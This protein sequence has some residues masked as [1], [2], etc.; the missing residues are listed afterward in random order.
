MSSFLP[1]RKKR[2]LRAHASQRSFALVITLAMVAIATILLILFVTAMSLDRSASSSYSQSVKAQEIGLGGLHLVVGQLQAEMYK[3]ASPDTNNSSTA[4]AIFTN[5]SPYNIAPQANVTNSA[6]PIMVKMSTN[7]AFYS[8]T[9]STSTLLATTNSTTTSSYNGRSVSTTRWNQAYFGSFP[10][11]GAAPYW[12]LMTR[13]GPT[14]ATGISPL[15][16][17]TGTSTLNN[18]STANTNYVIGRIAYAVYDESGLL[19]INAA[20]YNT[21]ALTASQILPIKGTLA[22]ADLNA[23]GITNT[24]AFIN[25]RN[26]AS[27]ANYVSI[28]T[29]FAATNGFQS[30]YPGDTTFLSR[31]DLI[32][33]AQSANTNYTGLTLSALTNLTTFT[34]EL[35]APSWAPSLN[36][37]I[38][39]T[40]AGQASAGGYAYANNA[41]TKITSTP[42]G[43]TQGVNKSG[44]ENPNP[45]IP[46]VR[47]STGGTITGY[48]T[49]GGTFTYTVNAGDPVVQHR[50]PLDRLNWVTP[51]GPSATLS[52][53]DA[54]Y[55]AGGTAAAVQACFGLIWG[56]AENKTNG[57]DTNWS[58]INVWKYVGPTLTTET[59]ISSA[60]ISPIET[61]S[62]VA[63]ESPPR[64]P[65]FFEL[66]Q[67][68]VLPGSLGNNL[69][70]TGNFQFMTNILQTYPYYQLMRIGAN[71]ITQAQ[72]SASSTQSS[73][74][75]INIEYNQQGYSFVASGVANLPYINALKFTE[76]TSATTTGTST[77]SVTPMATYGLVSLWNPHQQSSTTLKRPNVR[78]YVQ[79]DV[80]LASGWCTSY[81][82]IATAANTYGV[83]YA[84]APST[85][86]VQL[87]NTSGT[88]TGVNGFLNPFAITA[89]D[90]DP[91]NFSPTYATGTLGW[92]SST[93][94]ITYQSTSATYADSSVTYEALRF[95]DVNLTLQQTGAGI[96][97]ES[98][99]QTEST[100]YGPVHFSTIL[101]SPTT[102]GTPTTAAPIFQMIMK[103]QD[104]NDSSGN[105]WVP[106]DYW[107]GNN[108]WATWW[109]QFTMAGPTIAPAYTGSGGSATTTSPYTPLPTVDQTMHS[110]LV[111]GN[112]RYHS[113]TMMNPDPR[114]TRF[115]IF[116]L[117]GDDPTAATGINGTIVNPMIDSIWSGSGNTTAPFNIC[118]YGGGG[119]GSPGTAGN[120]VPNELNTVPT[121]F[122]NWFLPAYLTRNNTPYPNVAGSSTGTYFTAYQD[123]DGI[124][125]IADSGLFPTTS[126]I[127]APATSGNPYY[128]PNDTATIASGQRTG[129]RPLVLNRPYASVGELGYV[130]RDD[131]WRSL[132]FFSVFNNGSTT[133]S[134]SADSGLLDLFTVVD[135][136]NTVVAG[137]VNLNTQNTAVLA[138][139]L[140]STVANTGDTTHNTAVSNLSSPAAMASALATYTLA[141]PL[142]NK[143][144]LVT[145]FNP[146][147]LPYGSTAT[148]PFG[149]TDEQNVKAYRE[150]FIRSLADVGQTRTWNLMIDLVAQAG[151]Y[152]ATA[153]NADQFVV[154]GERR[155]WLHV[156][157]DRFTGKIIDQRLEVVAP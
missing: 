57:G 65:N 30:V 148:T 64:E 141:N 83:T 131:P 136:P 18:P 29:N 34:R 68:G 45:F 3:D 95:P 28:I 123:P 54:F 133:A 134:T 76:G 41:I 39:I 98:S 25:W 53:T 23:V 43:T 107:V 144:Q 152:P 124:Q 32:A 137:R 60:N 17:A 36:G 143:D 24:A 126:P 7:I 85:Y 106:Y 50:F 109:N 58:G 52:G 127:T 112:V 42:F 92:T 86:Y 142:V 102:T 61:L 11:N 56:A 73:A 20:G 93:G 21:N 67:A 100:S 71:I 146:T 47:Y 75:P 10:N 35:N 66:L 40:K 118:G 49:G 149:T 77:T 115:G 108:S 119:S 128:D 55:H 96:P 151:K 97:G 104:P 94:S 81:S 2:G 156:A 129:D 31:Q 27:Q 8:G 132:D 91:A 79:G 14:N 70:A 117:S 153:T 87:A 13:A 74:Y 63:K 155:Y 150:A 111:S 46:L 145:K 78:L 139:I 101:G 120:G 82:S 103:Y 125:R 88:M 51:K 5:V 135:S 84:M 22:G 37:S 4:V 33:A 113:G 80:S 15:F 48:L 16:G 44:S 26:N 1:L 9:N 90:V 116:P 122:K 147:S 59:Q 121:N 12:I 99:G 114:V 69:G 38:T 110:T 19:D 6:L 138:A 130:C 157:I 140:G 154:E 89:G 62:D 72:V 105:T